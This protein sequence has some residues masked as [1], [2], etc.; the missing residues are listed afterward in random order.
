MGTVDNTAE[1]PLDGVQS[2]AIGVYRNGTHVG[3]LYRVTEGSNLRFFHQKW[4]QDWDNS[5]PD[6]EK[7]PTLDQP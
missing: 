7:I 5:D 6:P 4:H 3:L 2:V 1:N